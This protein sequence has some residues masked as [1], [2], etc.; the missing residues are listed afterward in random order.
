[1]NCYFLEL[2][3]FHTLKN[4]QGNL[5][6]RINQ[7]IVYRFNFQGSTF[8]GEAQI[9]PMSHK[10]S[11]IIGEN[12][13]RFCDSFSVHEATEYEPI[14]EKIKR[15][16]WAEWLFAGVWCVQ[17]VFLSMT[18]ATI[19]VEVMQFYVCAGDIIAQQINK[20]E[21]NSERPQTV[22]HQ[23]GEWKGDA[24]GVFSKV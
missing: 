24:G 13:L 19:L 15:Y 17:F 8:D 21:T 11:E 14:C 18:N 12:L 6:G 16:N 4:L 23:N 20:C 9:H 7:H 1:M 5:I 10:R 22:T 2:R 3:A